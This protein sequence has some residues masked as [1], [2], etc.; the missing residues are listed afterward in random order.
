MKTQLNVILDTIFFSG[1]I[2]I[3]S[4]SWIKFYTHSVLNSSIFSAVITALFIIFFF[5]KTNKRVQKN[6]LGKQEKDQAKLLAMRLNMMDKQDVLSYFLSACTT[7]ENPKLTNCGI[8]F[9]SKD[10]KWLFAPIFSSTTL[11]TKLFISIINS[12]FKNDVKKIIFCTSKVDESVLSMQKEITIPC[13]FWD[14]FSLYNKKGRLLPPPICPQLVTHLKPRKN[15][16]MK[17]ALKKVRA[18]NYIYFGLILLIFSYFIPMKLYYLISGSLLLS[19]GV[20]ALV[21]NKKEPSGN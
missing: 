2:F 20:T 19:L 12:A 8:E 9:Y 3:F 4:F 7:K 10:E 6:K 5:K 18:K 17:N 1:I 15:E 13:E 16:I 21:L 11:D 14:E